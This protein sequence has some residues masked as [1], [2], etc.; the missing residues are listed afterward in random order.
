M[1]NSVLLPTS[2][3]IPI[4]YYYYFYVRGQYWGLNSVHHICEVTALPRSQSFC[5]VLCVLAMVLGFLSLGR[6]ARTVILLFP[7]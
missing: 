7:D 3:L 2:K 4:L 5:F 1:Y 6:G